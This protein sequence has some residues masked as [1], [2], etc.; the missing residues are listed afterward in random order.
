MSGPAPALTA[1]D[2]ERWR[3]AIRRDTFSNYHLEMG[4]ALASR[5]EDAAAIAQLRQALAIQPDFPLALQ[6]LHTLLLKTG[7]PE[8]AA[9]LLRAAVANNPDAAIN[10]QLAEALFQANRGD[11]DKAAQAVQAAGRL[12]GDTPAIL[13]VRAALSFITRGAWDTA[14]PDSLPDLRD[15]DIRPGL[16]ELYRRAAMMNI[17]TQRFEAAVAAFAALRIY[18]PDDHSLEVHH[19]QALLCT[20][21]FD[22]GVDI[23]DRMA[24]QRDAPQSSLTQHVRGALA[25]GRLE[26]AAALVR[27]RASDPAA[28]TL[29]GL[30][31]ANQ[32]NWQESVDLQREA[33]AASPNEAFVLS[34][35]GL[36]LLGLGQIDNALAAHQAALLIAPNDVWC[37]T[38]Q[39]LAL[40]AAGRAEE[41][42]AAHRQAME[43]GRAYLR[44]TIA[45]RKWAAADLLRIYTD[46]GAF[47]DPEGP[48]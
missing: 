23:M 24:A 2:I 29:S 6:Q 25:A 47:A 5:G 34:N 32:G 36:A 39:G 27:E 8:E 19:A 41:A 42:L 21:Q 16:V 22:A 48:K 7:Q 33:V 12:A 20:G 46:L 37:L 11:P 26:R 35:L 17:Q 10:A 40:T 3:Q 44:Y 14:P 30:I 9:E 28:K 38:N 43:A 45:Q 4:V 1:D 15:K 13:H 31:A 18:A